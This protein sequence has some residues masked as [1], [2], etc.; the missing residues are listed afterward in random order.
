M[1]NNPGGAAAP[2]AGDERS[3]PDRRNSRGNRGGRRSGARK[4]QT[5]RFRGKCEALKGN[6][7]V[8]S[9]GADFAKVNKEIAEYVSSTIPRAGEF[10]MGMINLNMD[11]LVEP[12][13]PPDPNAAD[14]VRSLEQWRS[15]HKRWSKRD[16]DRRNA[17]F[18]IFPIVL[19]QCDPAMIARMEADAEWDDIN[20]ASDVIRLLRLIRNCDV[21]RQTRREEDQTLLESTVEV[22]NCKQGTAT[23]WDYYRTFKERVNTA[24]RLGAAFGEHPER[25]HERLAEIAANI[26][27]PTDDERRQATTYVKQKY[28]ARLF[29]KNCDG[30]RYS[31]MHRDI[32]NDFIRGNDTYPDTLTTAYEYIVNYVQAQRQSRHPDE[33]GMSYYQGDELDDTQRNTDHQSS[34]STGRG[35]GGRGRGDGRGRGMPS[36]GGRDGRGCGRGGGRD[37]GRGRGRGR[38]GRVSNQEPRELGSAP[39]DGNAHNQEEADAPA[40]DDNAQYLLDNLEDAADYYSLP[41]NLEEII[42]MSSDH[43]ASTGMNRLLLDSCST[44]NLISNKELL[45]GIH[46]VPAGIRV[47]CNAGSITTNMKGYLGDFP[48]PVWYNPN[49]IVNILSFFIVAQHY[50]VRYDNSRHDEFFVTGP[51]GVEVGFSPTAKGLYSC[52]T[53]ATDAASEAWA[54]IN[55]ADDRRQ[56]FTKC[57]YRDAALARKAQNIMMFPTDRTLNKIVDRNLLANCPIR[58]QDIMAADHLFGK[59]VNALKGKTVYR[60]GKPVSGRSDGVPPNILKRCQRI[61]MSMDIM[62]INKIPFLITVSRGLRFGTVEVLKNRQIPTV[63]AALRNV[64]R[65]YRRRGFRV[66]ECHVDPEFQVLQ[67][68]FGDLTL[69]VC[70]ENEHVPD[71]ER[72]IRTTKDRVRSG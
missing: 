6:V 48:V 54:F 37:G 30:K 41:F 67:E 42:A 19:G 9:S 15:N 66:V 29:L 32:E 49:G 22:Y 50:H 21:Q 7:F 5:T 35:G 62:F 52:D 3:P 64:I 71:I 47:R 2:A 28:L 17:Q 26:D 46:E 8:L 11:D 69:N 53:A 72:Y 58:R 56:E 20:E 59:N 45:H 68:H 43:S 55:L 44:L 1:S 36:R 24:D 25:I 10:R 61:T 65:A 40:D 27:A 33:G 4:H 23:D 14:Y 51:N 31:A 34:Q 70:A 60:Q 13:F 63:V 57:E 38:S 12:E 18:Q 39:T 16:E